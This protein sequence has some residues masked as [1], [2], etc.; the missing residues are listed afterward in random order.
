SRAQ[1]PPSL[2]SPASTLY[3][4]SPSSSATPGTGAI[5][6]I[7]FG[8]FVVITLIVAFVWYRRRLTRVARP[9]TSFSPFTE[10]VAQIDTEKPERVTK[11]I[12]SP[13]TILSSSTPA[14]EHGMAF[15]AWSSSPERGNVAEA[16]VTT[17]IRKSQFSGRNNSGTGSSLNPVA[18]S[19]QSPLTPLPPSTA[20]GEVNTSLVLQENAIL[21]DQVR[22][23][24]ALQRTGGLGI[25]N[26]DEDHSG[27]H[28]PPPEY[29][30]R[31]SEE[32][33]R[34]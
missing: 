20:L 29:I 14:Q 7:V 1:S 17:T 10:A 25:L 30:G 28:E 24:A 12:D 5:A 15:V 18:S 22:H 34:T 23:F 8:V 31:E 26:G 32:E 2:A 19:V 21:R 16:G 27:Y 9:S 4:Q 11:H 6:G 13:S 3:S 33:I